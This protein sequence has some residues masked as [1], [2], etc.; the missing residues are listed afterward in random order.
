[1]NGSCLRESR[2]L[3]CSVTSKLDFLHL[4]YEISFSG[5]YALFFKCNFQPRMEYC[6]EV[7][8]HRCVNVDLFTVNKNSI[9]VWTSVS[10][11]YRHLPD[12][13]QKRVCDAAG[14]AL[15]E[16]PQ[17]LA[18]HCKIAMLSVIPPFWKAVH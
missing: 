11:H 10:K 5:F 14:L 12:R 2:F 16:L 15:V 17:P 13:Y 4:I 18:H 1:M 8:S 7:Y 3:R 9:S 6:C